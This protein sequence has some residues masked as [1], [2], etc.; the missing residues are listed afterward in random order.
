MMVQVEMPE[1]QLSSEASPEVS[2][3]PV[4]EAKAPPS[5]KGA[6]L[7]TSEAAASSSALS[8]DATTASS[9]W[10]DSEGEGWIKV[11]SPRRIHRTTTNTSSSPRKLDRTSTSTGSSSRGIYHTSSTKFAR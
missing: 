2:K 1:A 7:E 9:G 4:V 8:S 5:P 10:G 6:S 3:N 11:Q